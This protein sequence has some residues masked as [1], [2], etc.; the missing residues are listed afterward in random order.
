MKSLVPFSSSS[1]SVHSR[2][3]LSFSQYK[4]L[5]SASSSSS[6]IGEIASVPV[7]NSDSVEPNPASEPQNSIKIQTI[8]N[9]F[10]E[11]TRLSQIYVVDTLLSH[12]NDPLAALEY[13]RSVEKQPGFVREIG[14]SFFVLLHILPR[15]FD[16]LLNGYVRARRYKDAEDC[17]YSLVSRGI[18]PHV[19]I[20]N[21][22]LSSL[23]RSNMIDEA[24]GLFRDIVIKKQT[25]DCATVYMMMCT[26][27]REDK[28]EEAEKYFM[29]AKNSGIKLDLPVYFTAVRAA[30]MKL[31]S[32]VACGLLNEMKERGWVPPEGTFTHVICTCVKQRNMTEALRLK[33]EM[34]NS[35]HSMNVVVAT[36]LMKGY[37]QQGNLHSSLALF[38]KIVEDGIAPN[39]VTYA[40][41]IEGCC[42]NRNMVKAKE[43]YMQMK[44]A[45]KG[46][47]DVALE[48][49]SEMSERNLK[50]NVFTYS[51]LVDGYFKKGETE[52]AI[53]L[54][55]HMVSLGITPTDVTFNTVISGLC[56]VGQTTVAKAR[57]EKFVSM[58]FI[59]ICMTYNSLIDGFIKE[60]DMNA[61]LAVY[62]EMCEAGLFPNVV[63]YTTLIDGFCKT[64]NTDV[65]LKMHSEMH[66]KGIQMDITAYNV[67][68]DAFWKRGDMKR[69]CELFDEILE[70][71]LSPNT[72]VYN[73]MI[74]GFR[75]LYNMEAALDLYKR[76]KN[77]GF[78][79]MLAK[80]IV[81][82]VVTYSVLVRGL[83]NKGQLENARKILEEMLKKSITPNVLIYNT[84]IAGYFREGNLQ[85][86]FRLHDE[87]L[88]R[89]L[90]PDDTT[91]D[92]LVSGKFKEN[93]SPLGALSRPGSFAAEVLAALE[94]WRKSER[95]TMNQ[96]MRLFFDL[97]VGP[98]K[99]AGN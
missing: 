21:N 65:A 97:W 10:A 41:L 25:Y 7:R 58:G 8:Q 74:G 86:A 45:E 48:L 17:F 73:T 35:G 95:T 42:I 11:N 49:L 79:D 96:N 18:T 50:A 29:D 78:N 72:A 33:D 80:D 77:E 75:G 39:K 83:C 89:G 93:S 57:M 54:F 20:L 44:S 32:N 64:Q 61:A 30:C 40:V 37:C 23:I 68:I 55:D 90:A 47:V 12:I 9:P 14:D 88:D 22:F 66:A 2:L 15:V 85:E 24:R 59:P 31:E 56:K 62:R 46:N 87:M 60:G 6:P 53:E 36:S 94:L 19:R 4:C 3:L 1:S 99:D 91:Y 67:L 69:A 82:D 43:L 13:F 27:L 51:I 16:Y 71:G 52:K 92:I 84:L 81:P 26:A 28:V 63:T 38:D 34:I 70:V 76:M 98:S 5:S